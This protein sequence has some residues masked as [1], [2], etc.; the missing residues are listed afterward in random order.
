MRKLSFLVALVLAAVPA[1]AQLPLCGSFT[2]Q[3]YCQEFDGTGNAYSS[4]NDTASFGVFAQVYDDFVIAGHGQYSI[5]SVHFIGE[6]FNPPNQGPITGW[7]IN[8][9]NDAA[10]QPGGLKDTFH[11][12]GTGGETFVGSFGGFPTYRYDIALPDF[13]VDAGTI[14]WLDVY[15]D[16]AF[17]P[18]WGWSSG[19]GGDGI[20]YQDFFGTRSALAVDMAFGLD[21]HPMVVPEPG[22]IFMMGAGAL[23]VMGVI[24][25]KLF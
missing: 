9:Y 10:G 25:R 15:P 20:S 14:Y 19:L 2:N 8:L 12:G 5:D 18:Q 4:Q 6:Y 22:I 13:L 16:L 21:G 3:I 7:T 1:F 17:P 24:R 23:G 11:I